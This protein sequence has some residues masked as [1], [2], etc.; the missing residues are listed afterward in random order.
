MDEQIRVGEGNLG[1]ET[2]CIAIKRQRSP[3]FLGDNKNP[4]FLENFVLNSSRKWTT[5]G[6]EGWII[7]LPREAFSSFHD[8]LTCLNFANN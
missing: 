5:V 7:K 1:Y 2:V 6:Y 8:K 4:V 3:T